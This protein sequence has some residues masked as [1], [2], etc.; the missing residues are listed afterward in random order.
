[1]SEVGSARAYYGQGWGETALGTGA[2]RGRGRGGVSGWR[3]CASSAR[4]GCACVRAC[5]RVVTVPAIS[6]SP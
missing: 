1:M 3:A 5:L 6:R 2:G 4:V